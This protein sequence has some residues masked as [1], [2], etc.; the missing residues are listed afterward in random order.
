MAH[1]LTS[2]IAPSLDV[3]LPIVVTVEDNA[4][5]PEKMRDPLVYVLVLRCEQC[6][7][8]CISR[9][10]SSGI[11]SDVDEHRFV[12]EC[13]CGWR[14]EKHERGRAQFPNVLLA[15]RCLLSQRQGWRYT[16]PTAS[17]AQTHHIGSSIA[18]QEIT[19]GGMIRAQNHSSSAFSRGN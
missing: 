3:N 17:M 19:F 10:V 16:C 12:L 18:L 13:H 5:E 2:V 1:A 11:Y 14:A 6:S 7:W 4:M 9:V 8:P 15:F